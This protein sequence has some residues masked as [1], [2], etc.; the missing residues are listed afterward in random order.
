MALTHSCC[1]CSEAHYQL[2]QA[3]IG[4][5]NIWGTVEPWTKLEL[6]P[7][8]KCSPV[9]FLLFVSI[10]C[11]VLKHHLSMPQ[12]NRIGQMGT[13]WELTMSCSSFV[14]AASAN[15]ETTKQNKTNNS[16]H[17]CWRVCSISL[18]FLRKQTEQPLYREPICWWP[19]GLADFC[20]FTM[21]WR[22]GQGH[23][24]LT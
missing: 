24:L 11:L 3:S 22:P 5:S 21:E 2:S 15:T 7:L 10:N 14:F 9:A 12:Q 8:W 13:P 18:D 1:L 19:K 23:Y 20:A 17:F 4:W 16:P 6:Y